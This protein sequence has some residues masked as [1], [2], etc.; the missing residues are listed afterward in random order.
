MFDSANFSTEFQFHSDV[1]MSFQTESALIRQFGDSIDF[2]MN[3]MTQSSRHIELFHHLV[4]VSDAL[5]AC[6]TVVIM[7]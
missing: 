5:N 6:R 1:D 2:K 7:T 4:M 3:T